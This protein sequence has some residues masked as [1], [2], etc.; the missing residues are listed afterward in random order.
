MGCPLK[1]IGI[2]L[3][4]LVIGS[5]G[6][7]KL[8]LGKVG[9]AKI[10]VV[11]GRILSKLDGFQILLNRLPL[12]FLQVVDDAQ[13]VVC[14]TVLAIQFDGALKVFPRLFEALHR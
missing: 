3:Y 6:F 10:A 1:N 13:I 11:R 7:F 5:D 2:Q 4:S 9:R 8:L 12:L 14:V